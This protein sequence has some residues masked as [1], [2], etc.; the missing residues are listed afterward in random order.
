MARKR[1]SRRRVKM[2]LTRSM[3]TR[4]TSN[5]SK[6][7]LPK[8]QVSPE[9]KISSFKNKPRTEHKLNYHRLTTRKT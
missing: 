1:V 7:F 3:K 6:M 8:A 9:E 2:N 5:G 4:K